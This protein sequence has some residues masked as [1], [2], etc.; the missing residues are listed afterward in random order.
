MLALLLSGCASGRVRVPVMRPAEINLSRYPTLGVAGLA[1]GDGASTVTGLL[2]EA[3]IGTRRFQVV[4]RQR[5]DAV[6]SELQL[7]STDLADS[8]KSVKLGS[9]LVAGALIDGR[10]E[11][12]YVETP[13]EE[14]FRD[15]KGAEHVHRFTEARLT[16]HASL[17]VTDVTTGT[18]LLVREVEAVRGTFGSDAGAHLARSLLGAVLGHALDVEHDT[19]DAAPDRS[20]F[21]REARAEVVRRFVE[22]IT[23]T[24]QFVEVSFATDSAVPQLETGVAWARRGEWQK[25]QDTFGAAVQA[26]ERDVNISAPTLAKAY[27]DA[28][29]AQAYGGAPEKALPLLEKAYALSAERRMLDELDAAKRLIADRTRVAEQLPAQDR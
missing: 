3:L 14:T 5:I 16:V 6:M 1:G 28:G 12:R 17:R 26:C 24:Q 25:A 19:T 23:P 22:A 11:E 13:H 10:V 2:E 18:L 9:L 4:D 15:K 20:G 27:L 21:E 7:A 29:L 8:G